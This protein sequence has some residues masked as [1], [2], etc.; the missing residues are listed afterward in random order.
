MCCCCFCCC[1][2]VSLNFVL[3]NFKWL[4]IY[5][6]CFEFGSLFFFG[7]KV[8]LHLKQSLCHLA[9]KAITAFSE[10]GFP[11][12]SH[13]AANNFSKSTLQY[14]LPSRS[15]NGVPDIGFL[16]GPPQ[17]KWSS[18]HVRPR[19]F[20]TFCKERIIKWVKYDYD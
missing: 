16:H 15:K 19:A 6:L 1:V 3:L 17:T 9:S 12:P 13:F 11:Q 4:L 5:Y 18:C 2:F 10:I 20:T 14:G 8:T 7:R